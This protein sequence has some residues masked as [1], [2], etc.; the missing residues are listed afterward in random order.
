MQGR[1]LLLGKEQIAGRQG[2]ALRKQC[3]KK[4]G[5]KK[6]TSDSRGDKNR[7]G[8]MLLFSHLSVRARLLPFCLV[9][10]SGAKQESA[11]SSSSLPECCRE[12]V[13]E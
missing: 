4:F 7:S 12:Q 9:R 10:Q 1:C 13:R 6:V 5:E 8:L 11:R 2:V 3:G